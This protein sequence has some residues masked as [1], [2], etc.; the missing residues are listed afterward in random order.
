MAHHDAREGLKK[1]ECML[2]G[3][4]GSLASQGVNGALA[5]CVFCMDMRD[6]EGNLVAHYFDCVPMF[7]RHESK[8]WEYV[9]S[10]LWQLHNAGFFSGITRI[11]WWS[12]TGPNHFRVSNTLFAMREFQVVTGIRLPRPQC[13]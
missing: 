4:F 12:D 5:D 11:I 13:L 8:N 1:G 9:R 3:D 7:A 10:C 2:T 6:F